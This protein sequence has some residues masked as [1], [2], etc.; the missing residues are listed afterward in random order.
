MDMYINISETRKKGSNKPLLMMCDAL[1][2]V[3][4]C[5]FSDAYLW[6]LALS[7]FL[8]L[9]N[10]PSASISR[11]TLKKSCHP[12]WCLESLGGPLENL[13]SA[14][15]QMPGIS[16]TRLPMFT[17]RQSPEL[18]FWPEASSI[19]S[20]WSFGQQGLPGESLQRL[21]ETA[22]LCYFRRLPCRSEAFILMFSS[23]WSLF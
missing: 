23:R 5:D 22:S 15:S 4:Q 3:T 11:L 8:L 6:K 16:T 21:T 13:P 7:L 12:R 19:S 1:S 10:L 14:H 17:G 9:L 20:R 18:F 2:R